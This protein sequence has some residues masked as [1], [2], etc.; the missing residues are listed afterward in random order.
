MPQTPHRGK[1]KQVH[2]PPSRPFEGPIFG[3]KLISTPGS[4]LQMHMHKACLS[5]RQPYISGPTPINASD[6]ET[7]TLSGSRSIH[8]WM[9]PQ[10]EV[11]RGLLKPVYGFNCREKGA[12]QGYRD[13]QT[14]LTCVGEVALP[15]RAANIALG[16]FFLGV[17]SQNEAATKSAA[18]R[19]CALIRVRTSI[20]AHAQTIWGRWSTTRDLF[21]CCLS[22]QLVFLV[23]R[24]HYV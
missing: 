18:S 23:L 8:D 16:A 12:I 15:C 5:S 11:N 22:V 3:G 17:V 21:H 2:L 24:K 19:T 13:G 20:S 1:A 4:Q 10:R 6:T 14:S 7:H 9:W